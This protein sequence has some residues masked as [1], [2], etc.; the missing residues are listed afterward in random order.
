FYHYSSWGW[1][2]SWRHTPSYFKTYHVEYAAPREPVH[3]GQPHNV[4][5]HFVLKNWSR[6]HA[7]KKVVKQ[8]YQVKR[9]GR[10][11][12]QRLKE[13]KIKKEVP[14]SKAQVQLR[15]LLG[16]SGWQKRKLQRLCA[17]ELKE[18][19][20]AWVPRRSITTQDKD[21]GQAKGAMQLKKKRRSKRQ[22]SN[23]RFA[24]N[25]RN[26]WSQHHPFDLHIPYM[27]IS[28]NSSL[29]MFGCPSHSYFD[30]WMPYLSFYHGG[31]SLNC[32]A[33]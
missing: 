27:S 2:D 21:D 3:A 6:V 9:D 25:H 11:G 20:M 28:W 29:D 7:R 33:Y 23:M 5:D 12:Q 4:N 26:Y 14:L 30:P 15:C 13:P 31:L 18:K 32:Y 10:K 8:V 22:S 19:G 17:Q 1:D 16:S 24:P